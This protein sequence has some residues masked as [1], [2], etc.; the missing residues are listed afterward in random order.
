MAVNKVDLANGETLI[1]LTADSVTEDSLVVGHTAHGAD[2][3]VVNGANPYELASTNA[4]V[5][6]QTGLIEQIKSALANKAA[7]GSG[8]PTQEKSVEITANGTTEVLPDDGYALSKVGVTVNVP[9]PDGYIKPTGTL[10]VT[11]NGEHD[12]SQYAAV[13]VNVASSGSA[14]DPDLPAGYWRVDYIRFNGK[15]IVDTRKVCTQNTKIRMLFTRD[16]DNA[17]YMYGVVNSGNT[18]SVTAYM[19]SSGGSWQFGNKYSAKDI[20]ANE[21]LV[22]TAIV[23]KTGFIRADDTASISGVNDF[24]TIGS[25]TIGAVRNADG[26]V[27]AAQ[28]V[29]KILLFEMLNG[30]EEELKLIPVFNGQQYRFWDAVGQTFHD[31]ITDTALEGGNL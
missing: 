22:Q 14:G 12:V 1:D 11:E 3:E 19:T 27:A 26:T 16:S 21:E 5:S 10:E 13:N 31:S 17:M 28:F 20:V 23:T 25:L 8:L 2:G 18:A 15:C 9:I 6:E 7:G 29:G 30:D 24:E 4:A